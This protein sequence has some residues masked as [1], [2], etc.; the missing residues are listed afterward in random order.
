M[1]AVPVFSECEKRQKGDSDS[2]G[3]PLPSVRTVLKS[4]RGSTSQEV[5]KRGIQGISIQQKET[6]MSKTCRA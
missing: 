2:Q 1:A 6:V 5:A 4:T 3:Q